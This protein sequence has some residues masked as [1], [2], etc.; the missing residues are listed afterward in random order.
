MKK[1]I[2]INNDRFEILGILPANKNYNPNELKNQWKA[3][4]ILKNG[5]K[6]YMVRKLIEAEF[7]DIK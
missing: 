7:E 4:N 5:D 1:I 6:L 3:D 2:T